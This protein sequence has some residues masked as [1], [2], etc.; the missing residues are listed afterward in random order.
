MPDDFLDSVLPQLLHLCSNDCSLAVKCSSA[1][2]IG[3]LVS[4]HASLC[5]ESIPEI[6]EALFQLLIQLRGSNKVQIVCHA[7]ACV[8]EVRF[9]NNKWLTYT[10]YCRYFP[11]RNQYLFQVHLRASRNR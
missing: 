3:S 10:G 9:T 11:H 7:I 6:L 2:A 5:T 8:V 1:W 4:K